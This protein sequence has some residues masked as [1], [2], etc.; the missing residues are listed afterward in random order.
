MGEKSHFS[1]DH[2]GKKYL[3]EF[4]LLDDETDIFFSISPPNTTKN[5]RLYKQNKHKRTQ[6][7][8]EGRIVMDIGIHRTT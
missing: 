7:W 2:M 3:L 6:L 4:G 8:R 1:D 5:P